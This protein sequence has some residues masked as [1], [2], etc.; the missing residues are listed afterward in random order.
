M[1]TT[2]YNSLYI[3]DI[4]A[5]EEDEQNNLLMCSSQNW[6]HYF[7]VNSEEANIETLLN[8]SIIEFEN[9]HDFESYT[10]I[11]KVLDFS[12]EHEKPMVLVHG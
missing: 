12:L 3:L 11:N 1:K 8:V 7:S 6:E 4:D 10:K 2:H 5:L 9:K